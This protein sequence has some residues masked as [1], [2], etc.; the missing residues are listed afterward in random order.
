MLCIIYSVYVFILLEVINEDH[1]SIFCKRLSCPFTIIVLQVGIF[2]DR[3]EIHAT[4][5]RTEPES[6]AQCIYS[7]SQAQRLGLL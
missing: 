2:S 5:N 6:A 3:S 7:V 4:V 1:L